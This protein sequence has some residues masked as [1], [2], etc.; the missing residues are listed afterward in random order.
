MTVI[1]NS[2]NPKAFD[3]IKACVGMAGQ[4]ERTLDHNLVLVHFLNGERYW[5][6]AERLTTVDIEEV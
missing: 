6:A 1:L 4:V 3:G 2:T 5:C